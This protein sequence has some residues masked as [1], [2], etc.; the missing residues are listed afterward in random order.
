LRQAVNAFKFHGRLRL[1]E[2]L[3]ACLVRLLEAEAPVAPPFAEPPDGLVPVP[4]HPARRRER[5]FDQ[6]KRLA[7]VLSEATGIPVRER[8]LIRTRH[9]RP[10]VDLKPSERRENV[11][12]AFALRHPLPRSGVRVLLVDDVYTTGSTLEE[13]ARTLR[14]GGAGEVYAVT[15]TRAAP[16]WHPDVDLRDA[17]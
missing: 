6:A 5:G 9:T 12:G 14:R 4:L 3:G 13:C 8:L 1:A 7:A 15:V 17:V 2:P 11:R 16:E 10:Q